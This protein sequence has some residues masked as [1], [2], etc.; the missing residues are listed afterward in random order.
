MPLQLLLAACLAATAAVGTTPL[1]PGAHPAA[2]G[3]SLR[4]E[5]TSGPT[6]AQ[7][8]V[9]GFPVLGSPVLG[10]PGLR[11][12]AVGGP[13]WSWPLDPVPHVLRRFEAPPGPYAAGH[14]G[15]DLRT[16][17][18]AEVLSVAPGEVTHAGV[19]AG[20]G[21]VT[22]A[23]P[24]GLSSTYEPVDERVAE[25]QSVDV[26]DVLGVVQPTGPTGGHCGTLTCVHLGARR[27]HAYLDPY[28]L[29]RGGVAVLL[30]FTGPLR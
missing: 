3:R 5:P 18:A 11:A 20:R 23:H 10:S 19:V 12:D 14:R 24:G 8:P 27:G 1:G 9:L 6:A 7:A 15:L 26:G 29:L 16:A 2:E 28:P 13:A 21:T 22:V 30:P 17:P 25:G 4:A